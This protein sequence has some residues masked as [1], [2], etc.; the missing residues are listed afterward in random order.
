MQIIC[1]ICL[2]DLNFSNENISV[3]K[4]GHFFHHDCLQ[5]WIQIR[6]TCPE[7]RRPVGKNS[8]VKKVYPKINEHNTNVYNGDSSK[9]KELFDFIARNNECLQKAVSKRI[10]DL[11]N[12]KKNLKAELGELKTTFQENFEISQKNIS[13]LTK[14]NYYLKFTVEKLQREKD[15]LEKSV[16]DKIKKAVHPYLQMKKEIEGF[17]EKISL[18]TNTTPDITLPND[19]VFANSPSTSVGEFV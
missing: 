4:C 11:E 1:S 13:S 18:F 6:K 8:V 10:V 16:D 19:K 2:N 9:S 5:N 7:C 15:I 14:E 3:L 17:K 12:E